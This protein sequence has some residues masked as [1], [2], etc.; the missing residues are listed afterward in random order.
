M[1][2][3]NVKQSHQS[4]STKRTEKKKKF[5]FIFNIGVEFHKEENKI[6]LERKNRMNENGVGRRVHKKQR[7]RIW[8]H[9]IV[10]LKVFLISNSHKLV[11]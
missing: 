3:S 6:V 4:A 8:L 10:T 7:E 5:C 1:L 11:I 9:I 2:P